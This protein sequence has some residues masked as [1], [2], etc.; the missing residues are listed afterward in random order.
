MTL[1]LPGLP[2][3]CN[4]HYFLSP[5]YVPRYDDTTNHDPFTT[6]FV[7]MID[8]ASAPSYFY[9]DL[10]SRMIDRH[11]VARPMRRVK[12]MLLWVYQAKAVREEC[13]DEVA[14]LTSRRPSDPPARVRGYASINRTPLETR[15][16]ALA[17]LTSK[18]RCCARVRAGGDRSEGE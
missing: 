12:R 9:R 15:H 4:L 14:A 10:S 5:Y 6:E 13:H 3:I 11:R 17:P 7:Y 16:S 18:G 8:R 1:L 2:V